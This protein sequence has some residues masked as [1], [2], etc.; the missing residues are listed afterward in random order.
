MNLIEIY[1]TKDK[2]I[3][4]KFEGDSVWLTQY[5]MAELFN[6]DRTSILKH[7]KNIFKTKEL[8]EKQTCA[9]IAQVQKEGKKTVKRNSAL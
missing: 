9:R 6:T 3:D 1:R 4:V 5:Q 2:Q 8:D 7:I